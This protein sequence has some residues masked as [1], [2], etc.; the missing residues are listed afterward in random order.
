MPMRSSW[1]GFE[2]HFAE[3][4]HEPML[5]MDL[6]TCAHISES[7]CP[8]FSGNAGWQDLS[9]HSCISQLQPTGI[10]SI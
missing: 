3:N 5:W 6:A 1:V 9:L 7:E 8:A 10:R 2:R 4:Q